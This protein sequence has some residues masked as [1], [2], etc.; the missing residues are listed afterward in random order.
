[1]VELWCGGEEIENKIELWW[2]DEVLDYLKKIL[3]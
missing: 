3:L 2:E 1:M